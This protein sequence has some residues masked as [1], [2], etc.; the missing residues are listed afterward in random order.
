ML[1]RLYY[2]DVGSNHSSGNVS[3]CGFV[4]FLPESTHTVTRTSSPDCVLSVH[5]RVCTWKRFIRQ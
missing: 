1:S 2:T 4:V 3:Y 5:M